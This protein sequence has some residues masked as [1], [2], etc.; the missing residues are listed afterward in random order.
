M[1]S[2][3]ENIFDIFEHVLTDTNDY[4]FTTITTVVDPLPSTKDVNLSYSTDIQTEDTVKSGNAMNVAQP[5]QDCMWALN[6]IRQDVNA[7][8]P[9]FVLI[10]VRSRDEDKIWNTVP[11]FMYSSLRY[12]MTISV[13]PT[14]LP[15]SVTPL[16]MSQIRVVDEYGSEIRKENGESV[17]KGPKEF[18]NLEINR[19]TGRLE[20]E[21]CIKWQ[22]VSF[23]HAKRKFAFQVSFFDFSEGKMQLLFEARSASFITYARRPKVEDRVKKN[24]SYVP[25]QTAI[26]KKR[27][28][29]PKKKEE[30]RSDYYHKFTAILEQ[31]VQMKEN[32]SEQERQLASELV[33]ER[34]LSMEED[35]SIE[36][37]QT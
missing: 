25:V 4:C 7:L 23:H 14:S 9:A 2:Y 3:D 26:C 10:K 1:T 33:R 30:E 34:F 21:V 12:T 16:I 37:I 28:K 17:I 32:L 31:L 18:Q 5:T 27:K 13:D 35:L 6:K 22:S 15:D 11:E 29:G 8:V 36:G 19:E 24:P 20:T